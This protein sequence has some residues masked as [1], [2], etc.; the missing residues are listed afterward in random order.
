V[1]R[2]ALTID[3][4]TAEVLLAV[5]RG[6]RDDRSWNKLDDNERVIATQLVAASAITED[7]GMLVPNEELAYAFEPGQLFA[8]D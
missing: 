3:D 8:L 6:R 1:H 2:E 5:L 4:A 7:H